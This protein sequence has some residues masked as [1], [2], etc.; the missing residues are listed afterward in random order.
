MSRQN[1]YKLRKEREKKVADEDIVVALVKAE[2]LKQTRIGS[3][4]LYHML[5]ADFEKAGVKIGRDKY[6]DILRR[7]DLLLEPLPKS[8]KT[9]NS[10]HTL[11]V[12]RN[13][14][15]D[16]Q[17][18]M[19]NQ[20]LVSD[21]TFLRTDEGFEY[22]SLIMDRHSRNIVG[23]HCGDDLSTAG[24]LTALDQALLS[25]PEGSKPIHHSDRGCQYCSHAYAGRLKKH[26]LT[27]SMT[28]VN[29]CAE[30]AHAERLNG[31]LKQEYGLRVV[32]R[33]RAQARKAVAQAVWLY[34]NCRPHMSLN[35]CTPAEVHRRAA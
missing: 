9:T 12:F 25:L 2:R 22:L 20:I 1:Y 4:K 26:G 33:T 28:E 16:V 21:I 27:Q 10:R 14:T 18:T 30:N 24:C 11:P 17:T 6:F 32:F 3:R 34:N 23:F 7:R 15:A 5:K 13:L 35:M 31:I 19:P 8:P 29:H